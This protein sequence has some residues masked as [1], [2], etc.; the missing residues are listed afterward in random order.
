MLATFRAPGGRDLSPRARDLLQR[1]G[2]A[3]GVPLGEVAARLGLPMSTASVLVKGL[4]RRGLAERRRNPADERRLSIALTDRG[5]TRVETEALLDVELLTV[6]LGTLSPAERR[7]LVAG[8][9]R[10]AATVTND[11]SVSRRSH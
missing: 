11:P 8:L 3:E 6:A 2:A 9:E 1:L 10:L 7:A 4:E 5:R